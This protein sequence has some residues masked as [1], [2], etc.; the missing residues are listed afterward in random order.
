M[1]HNRQLNVFISA[2]HSSCRQI[3]ILA[4]VVLVI[5]ICCFNSWSWTTQ[6]E[7]CRIPLWHV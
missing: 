2:V 3:L 1:L 4:C 7:R 5:C 6:Q